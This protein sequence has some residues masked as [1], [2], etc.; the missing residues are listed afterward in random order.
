MLGLASALANRHQD[1]IR[2]R[3]GGRSLSRKVS[4]HAPPLR[5]RPR[6]TIIHHFPHFPR[7]RARPPPPLLPIPPSL[8]CAST[9]CSPPPCMSTRS[10]FLPRQV[11][12]PPHPCFPRA[13]F[14]PRRLGLLAHAALVLADAQV[15][16]ARYNTP[17]LRGCAAVLAP[18]ELGRASSPW[19]GARTSTSSSNLF[20]PLFIVLFLLCILEGDPGEHPPPLR[21]TTRTHTRA[22]SSS[23]HTHT[24]P[25]PSRPPRPLSLPLPPPRPSSSHRAPASVSRA[26][27]PR[28]QEPPPAT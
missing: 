11:H 22:L 12:P 4:P 28:W 7:S 3:G 23:L 16:E 26:R 20:S 6:P 14:R 10:T 1:D 21:H 18:G 9:P 13:D 2:R 19:G 27:A 15:E 17:R 8:P 24:T 25:L 5:T